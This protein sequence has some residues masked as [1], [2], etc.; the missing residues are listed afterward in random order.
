MNAVQERLRISPYAAGDAARIGPTR[1]GWPPES[2][3]PF[4]ARSWAFTAFDGEAVV[5]VGGVTKMDWRGIGWSAL[6]SA[7][8]PRALVLVRARMIEALAEAHAAGIV[9]I[10]TEVTAGFAGGHVWVR[11]LGFRFAG[12]VPGRVPGEYALRYAHT[13][14]E[15]Q[16]PPTRVRALLALTAETI[17]HIERS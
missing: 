15:A 12:I 2:I 10:E 7:I 3:E 11:S 1:E 17:D 14:A 16:W 4:A 6:S 5:A 9:T 8:D 13:A